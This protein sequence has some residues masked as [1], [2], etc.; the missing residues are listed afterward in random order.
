MM[1]S[2]PSSSDSVNFS[3]PPENT[4]MPLSWNG[5]WDAEM[6]RPAAKPWLRVR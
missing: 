6:T 4:L 5:L 3:P 2:T 1:A